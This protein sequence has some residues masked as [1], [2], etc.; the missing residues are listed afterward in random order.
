MGG[1]GNGRM[2]RNEGT[3]FKQ[4]GN[5]WTRLPPDPYIPARIRIQKRIRILKVNNDVPFWELLLWC[6]GC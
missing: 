5:S 4:E 6:I 1:Q 2:K 3:C